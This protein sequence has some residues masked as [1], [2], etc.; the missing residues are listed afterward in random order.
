MESLYIEPTKYSPE[1]NFDPE[2]GILEF[3]GKSYPENT[4]EFYAPVM[5]WL[6]EY[7]ASAPDGKTILDMEI[8]YFN[9]SSSKFFFDFFDVIEEASDQ[10]FDIK[11]NWIYHKDNE[12]AL[13]AGEDFMEDF[14]SL[15][16]NLVEEQASR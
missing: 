11:I 7:I 5:K 2:S 12:N 10:G 1:I 14:E 9:S 3:R 8:I 6:E 15:D 16:F 4:F 13:E